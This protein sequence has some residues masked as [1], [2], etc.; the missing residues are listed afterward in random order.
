MLLF[1]NGWSLM[2]DGHVLGNVIDPENSDYPIRT[3]KVIDIT[4][5]LGGTSLLETENMGFELG[6]PKGKCVECGELKPIND[7]SLLCYDCDV[8]V[9]MG[10]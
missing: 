3:P 1:I 10:Y 6:D 7:E 9:E 5:I 8:D 2:D 4:P